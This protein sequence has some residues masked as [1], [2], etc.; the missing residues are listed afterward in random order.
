[1]SPSVIHASF[2]TFMRDAVV[3]RQA[4]PAARRLDLEW[5]GG[6]R[7]IFGRFLHHGRRW[8]VHSDTHFEPLEIAH[9]AV[10][11]DPGADPFDE[12]HTVSGKCLVLVPALRARQAGRHK[13]LYIY[14]E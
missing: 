14:E 1:M 8:K 9:R 2:S 12:E 10:R 11:Q 13:H 6:N 5:S 3:L 7:A 4:N